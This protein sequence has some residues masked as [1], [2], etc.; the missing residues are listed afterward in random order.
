MRCLLIGEKPE[1][2]DKSLFGSNS[3]PSGLTLNGLVGEYGS[4]YASIFLAS[5]FLYLR[6][7]LW[8]TLSLSCSFLV[9]GSGHWSCAKLVIWCGS[10]LSISNGGCST[11]IGFFYFPSSGCI[12]ERS[13]WYKVLVDIAGC[14]YKISTIRR[15]MKT[16]WWCFC[17]S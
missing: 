7:S 2:G 10:V 6:W 17:N 12:S 9:V 15:R 8:Y 5:C 1:R 11:G 13:S 4:S 3:S 16:E 14:L